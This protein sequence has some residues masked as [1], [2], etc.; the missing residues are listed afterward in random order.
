MSMESVSYRMTAMHLRIEL[1]FCLLEYVQ[2]FWGWAISA[3]Y[4]L[5]CQPIIE[6]RGVK[7]KETENT[8]KQRKES[9]RQIPNCGIAYAERVLANGR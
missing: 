6:K 3:L 4:D 9:N 2:Y 1:F 7:L 8:E 5:F